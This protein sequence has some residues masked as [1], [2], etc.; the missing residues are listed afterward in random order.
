[1]NALRA[2]FLAFAMAFAPAA[3]AND[4]IT[5]L[6]DN[7]T[8]IKVPERTATLVIGNPMIAD[9]SMQRNGIMV[10]TGKA[11]GETNLLALDESGGLVS[12]TKLRVQRSPRNQVVVFRGSESETYS[13]TP[14]CA[15]VLVLGDSEKHFAKVGGQTTNRNSLAAPQR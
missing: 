3:L 6:L 5:L 15:P 11:F 8:V 9:V 10:L 14:E 12:E 4:G 13:C 7:A 2:G 1:M